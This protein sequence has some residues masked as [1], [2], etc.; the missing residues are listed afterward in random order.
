MT[1]RRKLEAMAAMQ[2]G[3]ARRHSECPS[4]SFDRICYFV[5][6]V[7]KFE[8]A[9]TAEISYADHRWMRRERQREMD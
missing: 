3:P 5:L 8:A 1:T 6:E 4:G 7:E 9:E 2:G